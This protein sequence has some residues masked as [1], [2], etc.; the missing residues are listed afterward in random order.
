[1]T[2]KVMALIV[3]I[4]YIALGLLSVHFLAEE[5]DPNDEYS[6]D[7]IFTVPFLVFLFG[8]IFLPF[9]AIGK[10]CIWIN[11]QLHKLIKPKNRH[12]LLDPD[13]EQALRELE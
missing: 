12:P 9:I 6:N 10:T 11:K 7:D 3:I 2:D 8:F 1:M 4:V 5:P 13:Y